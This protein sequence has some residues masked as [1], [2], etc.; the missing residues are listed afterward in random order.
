MTRTTPPLTPELIERFE[1]TVARPARF[2]RVNGQLSISRL[3]G[4]VD[5]VR[6]RRLLKPP[7]RYLQ[8]VSDRDPFVRL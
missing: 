3:V 7:E 4:D 8:D 6:H 2:P 1:A 5:G